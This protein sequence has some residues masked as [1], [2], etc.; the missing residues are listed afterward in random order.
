MGNPLLEPQPQRV[1]ADDGLGFVDAEDIPDKAFR[2]SRGIKKA[3][4]ARDRTRQRKKSGIV[5][6]KK[7][8]ADD[9]DNEIQRQI[10]NADLSGKAKSIF[11]SN[12]MSFGGNA[13]TL[14]GCGSNNGLP[15]QSTNLLP[16]LYNE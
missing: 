8:S 10:D 2:E 11:L 7:P 1:P 3:Q 15:I 6:D 13:G 5:G 4:E 14:C 16:V 9:L 12:A